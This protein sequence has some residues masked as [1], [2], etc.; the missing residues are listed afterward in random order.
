MPIQNKKSFQRIYDFKYEILKIPGSHS[1]LG[2]Y[3]PCTKNKFFID[4]KAKCQNFSPICYV[5]FSKRK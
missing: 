1:F 4:L 3:I 5:V 2:Y